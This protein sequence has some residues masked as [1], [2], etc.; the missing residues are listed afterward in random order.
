MWTNPQISE[1]LMNSGQLF[2]TCDSIS[3]RILMFKSSIGSVPRQSNFWTPA[4]MR[5]PRPGP[6]AP[7][8]AFAAQAARAQLERLSAAAPGRPSRRCWW[9]TVHQLMKTI[10]R[11]IA[12]GKS[13]SI[14]ES[15]L[16]ACWQN[17]NIW[18]LSSREKKRS[19]KKNRNLQI[20]SKRFSTSVW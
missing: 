1:F 2:L 10:S 3:V 8:V 11:W 5:W 16:T 4:C 6:R 19:Q 7:A 20:L 13:P 18:K 15:F 9:I 12:V 17:V 14:S